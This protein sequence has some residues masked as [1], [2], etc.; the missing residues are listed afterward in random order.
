MLGRHLLGLYEKALSPEDT[1]PKRLEKTRALGFDYMEISIDE[2]DARLDR[3]NWPAMRVRELR[4]ACEDAGVPLMSMCLSAHRR[5]PFGSADSTTRKRA[6]ELMQRAIDF[7]LELGIRVIQLAGYDVY[8]EPSTERSRQAFFDGLSWAASCAA[9]KQMMLGVEIMDTAFYSSISTHMEYQEKIG[10]PWLRVYP[11][12][13]NLTAWG[14][15][16]RHELT[17]GAGSMVAVHLKDTLAVKDGSGGK[18]KEVPFGAGCVD[19]P[20]CFQQLETLGYSGPYL[21]EMW[22]SPNRDDRE[23]VAEAKAFIEACYQRAMP[24]DTMIT[25]Q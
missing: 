1:W 16:V 22:H 8:Y 21:L 9:Q 20:G 10:S 23:S 25:K 12:I 2:S 18:F 24:T 19:F 15:D 11:D 7:S 14:N 17:L 5:F 3:L 6:Y 4:R 13:G